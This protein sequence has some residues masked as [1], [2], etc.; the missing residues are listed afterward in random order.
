MGGDFSIGKATQPSIGRHFFESCNQNAIRD[1]D[2]F[3]LED[4]R[5]KKRYTI[6]FWPPIAKEPFNHM[7]K[8]LHLDSKKV[9]DQIIF[10]IDKINSSTGERWKRNLD[11][12]HGG[13]S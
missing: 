3:H 1:E 12:S 13:T 7:N 10:R 4:A 8:G 5:Q 6:S 11:F 2:L 9:V